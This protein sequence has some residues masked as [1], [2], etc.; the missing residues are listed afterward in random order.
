MSGEQESFAIIEEG[1]L[2]GVRRLGAA[3]LLGHDSDAEPEDALGFPSLVLTKRRQGAA[4]QGGAF[5]K[6]VR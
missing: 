4:L 5:I 1:R 2:L 6:N 3:L